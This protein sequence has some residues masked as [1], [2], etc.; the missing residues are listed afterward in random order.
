MH[1]SIVSFTFWFLRYKIF[2]QI[3]TTVN[4]DIFAQLSPMEPY[5]A[6]SCVLIFH[7]HAS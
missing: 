7:A 4:V 3:Q 1:C 2:Q 6:Y 5:G